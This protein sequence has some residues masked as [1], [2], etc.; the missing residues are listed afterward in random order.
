MS[1]NSDKTY[2]NAT[3]VFGNVTATLYDVYH[4]DFISIGTEHI[5]GLYGGGNF[6]MV[7]G[8]RELNIS[9]YGT[10]YFSLDQQINLDTYRG[11]SNR[12]RAYFKLKY[13]CNTTTTFHAEG[14]A[15]SRQYTAGEKIDEDV[16]LRLLDKYG[17]Q[18]EAAFTPWGICSIYAGRLL[19]TI[20]RA[21]FCGVFGSRMV[22]QGA[23]DRVAETEQNTDFTINRVGELSL[24]KMRSVITADSGDDALH[25]NYFGIYSVVNYLGN[26]TSDQHF[27]DDYEGSVEEGAGKT[28]YGFK[29][30]NPTS[31]KRNKAKGPH[32]VALASGVHL[33]LTTENSTEDHKDYGYITGVVELDLIN[34]KKDKVM[35]GG[36]VYAKNEHRVP[37]YFPNK[38]NVLLS[39][40]NQRVGDE[41]IT[42]K[43]FYYENKDLPTGSE[44]EGAKTFNLNSSE[45]AVAFELMSWQTSGNFI[46]PEKQIVDDCY[47]TNNAYDPTKSPYSE[48]HYWYV[49]GEVYVY[50]QIVTAYTGSAS[51]YQK[52]SQLNLTI[53]AAS[54]GK[55]QL[56]NVKPNLYAY[57]MPREKESTDKVKIGSIEDADH[58]PIDQVTVN[59]EHDS[60]KLNDVIT[61][62]DWHQLTED[63]RANFVTNTYVNCFTI[64]VT[65]E[66][67]GN[68]VK[69]V[70]EAGEYVMCDADKDATVT[71]FNNGKIKDAEGN[72]IKMADGKTDADF[73]YIFRSSNNISHNE[74]YVLTFDMTTP[75]IWGKYYTSKTHSADQT[76][77]TGGDNYLSA[78]TYYPTTGGVYGTHN[79]T[80][81]EII[82]KATVDA[83]PTGFENK[84]KP[85]YVAVNKVTYTS[86]G[87]TATANEGSAISETVFN[88]ISN[89]DPGKANFEPAYVCISTVK[90][91][92]GVYLGKGD[93]KSS[94]QIAALKD[95][96]A[97]KIQR[98]GDKEIT[99]PDQ[100]KRNEID[101]AMKEAYI[102]VEGGQFGGQQFYNS[103]NYDV[104]DAW[105]A[106]S[107]TD[108]TTGGFTFN[109][110]ALDLLVDQDYV[111]VHSNTDIQ[112]PEETR[113]Q[114]AYGSTYSSQVP[115]EYDAICDKA[116]TGVNSTS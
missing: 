31:S 24:N 100:D 23:K 40:Y 30:S 68:P 77:Q 55:L 114:E 29:A 35:G 44:A 52:E 93:L 84:V 3:T 91:A 7:D 105:C 58:N 98:D 70:Y 13:E 45:S 25:G 108:R 83:Y 85:A 6:S 75:T 19:N 96:Y 48:A 94:N 66:K 18:V 73:D 71:L 65:T 47:P 76:N 43:R 54:N 59:N 81:G 109:Q 42:Y 102:C 79:Y 20:Q 8:Y 16:Y 12:E 74:G 9:N 15:D 95:Q 1:T 106:L 90:L 60:Y 26:M 67:E 33:E 46:H 115:I 49:K 27:D 62:W 32:Q 38:K 21:D 101:A 34:V 39:D 110:D 72:T 111:T 53:T 17:S 2:A 104:I 107:K 92:E 89:D 113:T 69:T 57:Y 36:F 61:W 10:D 80:V 86:G 22:L 87:N 14:V 82:T 88:G 51:A 63:E 64:E 78:P 56:L 5:G 37:K 4:R 97:I 99:V 103:Q 50:D 41:A 11:L 112:Y 28:Y 116:F